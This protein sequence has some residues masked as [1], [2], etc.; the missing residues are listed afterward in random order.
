MRI[1]RVLIAGFLAGLAHGQTAPSFALVIGND[2]YRDRPL[3]TPIHDAEAVASLLRDHFG[4]RT[5]LLRDAK[6]RDI[7]LALEQYRKTLPPESALLIYYAG[8][9]QT[10]PEADNKAYWWP[11]DAEPDNKAEWI[12]SDDIVTAVKT[13]PAKHVLIVSDSCFS[14]ALTRG[15]TRAE[16]FSPG[17]DRAR[18]LERLRQ[19]ASRELFASGGNE[20]VADGGADN[21]SIFAAAFIAALQRIEFDDFAVEEIFGDLRESVGGRSSQ[22]P[23]LDPIRNSGHDGGSFVFHRVTAAKLGVTE[24]EHEAIPAAGVSARVM[25]APSGLQ[26]VRIPAG[27]ATLGMSS[28]GAGGTDLQPSEFES[29]GFWMNRTE[30]TVGAY[31]RFAR[32]RGRPLPATAR[33][34]GQVLNQNWASANLPMTMVDWQDATDYCKWDGGRLPSEFE[35]EYAARG[36]TTQSLYGPLEEIAWYANNSGPQPIDGDDL[37]TIQA[38]KVW[39]RYERLLVAHGVTIHPVG[40][41]KPNAFGLY[42]MLGNVVEWTEGNYAP[43]G[44]EKAVRGLAWGFVGSDARVSVRNKYVPT[45]RNPYLGFRCVI[46]SN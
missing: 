31:L 16:S 6:R 15:V 29:P 44:I 35:W 36:G 12:S 4:F 18:V 26:Y 9:G 34:A 10:D 13:L 33:V 24:A 14:G 23:E 2:H 5:T 30:V 43:N 25:P 1:S 38:H 22:L 42:D 39:T 37:W 3:R 32:A 20:P 45:T 28:G 27:H 21:H 17:A 41:K 7:M 40:Q 19:R 8:H 46:D 11:V